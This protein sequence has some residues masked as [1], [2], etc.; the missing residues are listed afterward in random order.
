MKSAKKGNMH[1]ILIERGEMVIAKIVEYCREHR[2][3][4]GFLTGIGAVDE[5][6]IAHYVVDHK[7]YTTRTFDE[8][9]EIAHLSGNVAMMDDAP[10]LHC[11]IALGRKDFSIVGGHLKEARVHAVCEV[12]LLEGDLRLLRSRDEGLGLNVWDF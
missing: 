8:P 5:A 9:M 11:H 12:Y 3:R 10:Y 4:S 2:I 1:I 7:K 6:E